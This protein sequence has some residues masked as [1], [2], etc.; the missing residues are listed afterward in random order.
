MSPI[1][2]E[3][4]KDGKFINKGLWLGP[5]YKM[6]WTT[7]H[8]NTF[9]VKSTLK[10]IKDGNLLQFSST[11]TWPWKGIWKL[12]VIPKIK[13][14][15]WKLLN[16]G[17]PTKYKLLS[18][19][20]KGNVECEL[21]KEAK[22]NDYHI[23]FQ[24][25][26]NTQAWSLIA[27]FTKVRIDHNLIV[28]ILGY[29][30]HSPHWSPSKGQSIYTIILTTLWYLWY[31]KYQMIFNNSRINPRDLSCKIF[32]HSLEHK[33]IFKQVEDINEIFLEPESYDFVARID[34]SF[35]NSQVLAGAGWTLSKRNDDR[36]AVEALKLRIPLRHNC[37]LCLVL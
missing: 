21:C 33:H 20:W 32:N 6:I 7:T 16:R 10:L 13:V 12:T 15:L 36:I 4:L 28:F 2:K 31:A 27:D 30:G 23:L 14:F 19:W 25:S 18:R 5:N 34:G 9:S 29:T 3:I 17:L 35:K 1:L 22:E 24:W 37:L 11:S 8:N 26:Y